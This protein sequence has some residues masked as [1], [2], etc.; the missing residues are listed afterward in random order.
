MG[1]VGTGVGVVR[2][3]CGSEWWCSY[4]YGCGGVMVLK[5]QNNKIGM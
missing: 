3:R 2:Y 5:L 4:R 1:G